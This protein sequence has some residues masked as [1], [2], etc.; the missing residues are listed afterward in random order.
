MLDALDELSP[1][2]D[3]KEMLRILSQPDM[4]G[5]EGPKLRIFIASRP[6][7]HMR[8]IFASMGG[9]GQYETRK[10]ELHSVDD[11]AARSDVPSVLEGGVAKFTSAFRDLTDFPKEWPSPQ[12]FGKL[13]DDCGMYFAYATMAVRFIGD[14]GIC[15]P[16]GQLHDMIQIKED[17]RVEDGSIGPYIELDGLYLSVIQR[18]ALNL[19]HFR[20]EHIKRFRSVIATLVCLR[21]TTVHI[22]PF[23]ISIYP[24]EKNSLL[25]APPAFCD[26]R[27]G[28]R[29]R[30]GAV[31]PPIVPGFSNGSKALHGRHVP[32]R[33]L[34]ARVLHGLAVHEHH[35]L[36][37]I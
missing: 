28:Q 20:R 31:L 7:A 25:T 16:V 10:L 36:L 13:A 29:C 37:P 17:K 23:K 15:D 11:K 34:G 8:L 27:S 3:V 22:W 6:E 2:L 9:E 14:E 26:Y 1:D 19:K 35:A 18:A 33:G 32:Y 21:K 12:Q 4:I 30:F 5:S 24:N